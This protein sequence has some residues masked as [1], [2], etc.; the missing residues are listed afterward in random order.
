MRG[1]LETY[2]REES[3]KHIKRYMSKLRGAAADRVHYEKRTA[4]TAALPQR[5][6]PRFWDLDQQFNPFYVRSHAPSI[7]HALARK[8]RAGEYAARPCLRVQVPKPS[9]GTR[10]ISIFTVVDSAVSSWLFANLLRR[11]YPGFSGYAYAYRLDRNA[12]HAIEHIAAA[13]ASK[14]RAYILEYDFTKYF[15]SVKHEYLL[16]VIGKYCKVS[17]RERTLIEA[18]LNYAYADG[19]QSYSAHDFQRSLLGFP[20]GATISLFLANMAC[21]ELDRE[22]ERTGA[23]F[24]RYADD[25]VILCDDYGCAHRLAGIMLEHGNRS[26]TAIN[27]TKSPGIS[28]VADPSTAEL[29][30]KS[31]FTFLGH[32]ISPSGVSPSARAIARMKRHASVI[33]YK[34]LLLHPK[35]GEINSTRMLHGV[36]WDLVTCINELRRYL[37]GPIS[38]AHLDGALM[39]TRPL[40]LSMCALSYFPLVKGPEPFIKLDGWLADVLFRAYEKRRRIFAALGI[41][42]PRIMKMALVDGSWYSEALPNEPALPSVVRSWRYV[43]KCYLAYGIRLYSA[44]PPYNW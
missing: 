36:D 40:R 1:Q 21:F 12:Q 41:S 20:Q 10:G 13:L 17:P 9:G 33:I 42:L 35:R 22:I 7:A 2:L 43:R 6:T 15:D 26:G 30:A 23:T 32:Q 27:I 4:N 38:G 31:S 16:D 44:P 5:T 14:R 8:I 29:K 11:N 24:A 28:L 37:Y 18:F 3:E 25:T 34:H 39:K 19:F